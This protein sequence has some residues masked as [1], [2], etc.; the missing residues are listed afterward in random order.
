MP[1]K[2]NRLNFLINIINIKKSKPSHIDG[3][4]DDSDI[5]NHFSS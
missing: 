3:H 2:F 5:A 1:E 4:T